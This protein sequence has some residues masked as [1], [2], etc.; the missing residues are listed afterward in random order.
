VVPAA[1]R[2]PTASTAGTNEV[3]AGAIGPLPE[4]ERGDEGREQ[5]Y[6]PPPPG[7]LLHRRF[8]V[9]ES[10]GLPEAGPTD[11]EVVGH[12]IGRERPGEVRADGEVGDDR[13]EPG[14]SDHEL[15]A[16]V[17]V[18][19]ADALGMAGFVELG[20]GRLGAGPDGEPR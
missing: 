14:M 8:G 6:A 9:N 19:N 17:A 15:R 3:P 18:A 1:P 20:G 10:A 11:G 7:L 5:R 16:L 12:L 13:P 4:R 2:P